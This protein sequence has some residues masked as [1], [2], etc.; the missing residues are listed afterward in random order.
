M[1]L[2]DFNGAALI[3]TSVFQKAGQVLYIMLVKGLAFVWL[4][5]GVL[6]SLYQEA[7]GGAG[8]VPDMPCIYAGCAQQ[9]AKCL[10]QFVR[11]VLYTV[12]IA[13]IG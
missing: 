11:W 8:T 3:L 7:V 9:H 1:H 5:L 6:L 12:T 13:T 10:N 4:V 2:F